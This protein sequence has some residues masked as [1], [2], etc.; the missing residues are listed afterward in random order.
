VAAGH[1]LPFAEGVV[2]WLVETLGSALIGVLIGGMIVAAMHL[3]PA[4]H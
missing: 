1:A 4:K 3:R 2:E